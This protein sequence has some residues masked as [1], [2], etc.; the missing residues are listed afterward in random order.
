MNNY[1]KAKL[2]TLASVLSLLYF[3]PEAP[4]TILSRQGP[5][6]CCGVSA[7]AAVSGHFWMYNAKIFSKSACNTFSAARCMQP[8]TLTYLAASMSNKY[9]KQFLKV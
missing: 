2:L 5:I 4:S 1:S 7:I 8:G 6:N 3:L 9:H